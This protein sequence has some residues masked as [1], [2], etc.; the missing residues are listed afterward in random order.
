M[1]VQEVGKTFVSTQDVLS[2]QARG[3]LGVARD[4]G[5][6][7][8]LVLGTGTCHAV[9]DAQL[10]H[11]ITLGFF[12]RVVDRRH[13]VRHIRFAVQGVVEIAIQIAPTDRVAFL[14]EGFAA[15]F[16]LGQCG[17]GYPDQRL[18]NDFALQQGAKA[19]DLPDLFAC[20]A[21][22]GVTMVPLDLHQPMLLEPR[23]G[24]SHGDA[25]GVEMARQFFL[26]QRV[27]IWKVASDHGPA[28]AF[29]D[30]VGGGW[31]CARVHFDDLHGHCVLGSVWCPG[32]SRFG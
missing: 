14:R 12:E 5:I 8:R 29:E 18:G 2:R 25:A 4:T 16:C 6:Q 15:L 26:P 1:L 23:K 10:V 22:N 9:R 20:Q 32:T 17:V 31:C 21:R 27:A 28:N 7:D 11:Q 3:G 24:L 19:A 30:H 13:V